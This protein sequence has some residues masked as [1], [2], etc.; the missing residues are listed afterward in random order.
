MKNKNGR[1]TKYDPKYVKMIYE[2]MNQATAQN[3]ALPSVEGFALKIDVTKKTIYN[4]SKKN[5]EFLH[6]LRILK[7][8]QKEELV[9]IGI[10][11]GKEI[12]A[13]IVALM[14]KVN[15][16][17]VET[18]KQDITSGGSSISPVLVKFIETKDGDTNSD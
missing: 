1:P 7:M 15:H 12:N 9:S 14:L 16:K 10:F 6:A 11:R 17:M 18:T 3:M 4:W 13:N 5:K 2:Y 8:R